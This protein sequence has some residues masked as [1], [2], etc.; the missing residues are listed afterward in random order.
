MEKIDA[1]SLSTDAQ[2]QL[3]HQAIRLRED[4]RTYDEI[5]NRP[6]FTGG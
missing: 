2:Q 5:V 4:G 3:R 1:R 6:G